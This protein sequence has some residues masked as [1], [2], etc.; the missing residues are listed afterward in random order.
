[1]EKYYIDGIPTILDIRYADKPLIILIHGLGGRKEH[2]VKF[3]KFFNGYNLAAF[4]ARFHGE[5]KRGSIIEVLKQD[6]RAIREIIIGSSEDLSK[7]IDYV[8]EKY[9]VNDIGVVGTSMGGLITFKSISIDKRISVAASLISGSISCI[10][11]S[12]SIILKEIEHRRYLLKM[13]LRRYLDLIREIDVIYFAD[14]CKPT[15]ILLTGG[16]GDNIIPIECTIAAYEALRKA[17]GADSNRIKFVKYRGVGHRITR[18][19]LME[20]L[21]WLNRFLNVK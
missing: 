9:R 6:P 18:D 11:K 16:E 2:S 5:R 10:L 3:F 1:M 15:P 14:Q 8:L 4:D 7:I 12:K 19:M 13:F 20:T 21:D 17:Y